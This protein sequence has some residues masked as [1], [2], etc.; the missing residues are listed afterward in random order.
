M[1]E[2][3][4]NP[5]AWAFTSTQASLWIL[6]LARVTGL[7]AGLPG[8]G[9]DRMPVRARAALAAL[10]SLLVLP[11]AGGPKALPTGLWDLTMLLAV[12]FAAGLLLGTLVAWVVEAVTF[13]ANLMDTQMGFSFMQIVDPVNATNASVSGALLGQVAVLLVFILGI[14]H[15]VILGLVESYQ[16][17][18]M[19]AGFPLRG[20]E[21][22]G[23]LGRLLAKGV[24][25]AMPVMAV[26][27]IVDVLQGIAGK[28]MPQ[29]QLL[30]LMFPVKIALGLVLLGFLLREFP[31]W[32]GPLLRRA[33]SLAL[34]LMR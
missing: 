33:P 14:H 30:Q 20:M 24:Q 23:V 9:Q 22:V 4:Q 7:L 28:L 17:V 2:V 1:T 10:L 11:A 18:P 26:L 34:E 5:A 8:L 27:I 16:V 19:G 32:L 13:G 12:E 15:Q 29:L 3:L 31:A 21:F 6:V 25:L